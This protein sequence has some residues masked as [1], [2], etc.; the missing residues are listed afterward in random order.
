MLRLAFTLSLTLA[1][2][3]APGCTSE[4]ADSPDATAELMPLGASG[5]SGTVS[6]TLLGEGKVQIDADITGLTPGMHGMHVHEWGDCSAP[7]GMSAGGHF[8]PDMVDH[9]MPGGATRH[10]GDF[11]NLEADASGRAVFSL[12]T[13]T[14]TFSLAGDKYDV[15]G[16]A[17][18]VHENPDD[19]SQPTGNAGG[20]LACGVI[21]GFSGKG[22]VL[23]PGS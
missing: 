12:V 18:I 23:A 17:I 9:G 22:P 20:R 16:R 6:F 1:V 11:G 19:F 3:A 13:D 10:P 8:N 4:P 2:L 21:E 14:A 15:T 7:D 5:V